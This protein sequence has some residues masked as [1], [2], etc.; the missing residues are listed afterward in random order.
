MGSSAAPIVLVART[1]E[2]G[3]MI[4][5]R[6]YVY[7]YALGYLCVNNPELT[8]YQQVAEFTATEHEAQC[9]LNLFRGV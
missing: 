9:V 7:K 3:K 1:W 5:A 8:Q 4:E 2:I 6:W